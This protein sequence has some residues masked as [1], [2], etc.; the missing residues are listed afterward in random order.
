MQRSQW[1]HDIAMRRIGMRARLLPSALGS[2]QPVGC[3][4]LT[5]FLVNDTVAI[6][7]G[8]LG[9]YLT[10]AEQA[11]VRHVFISHSHLDHTGSL[12]MF[13]DNIYDRRGEPVTVHA[14]ADV[15]D[16]VQEHLLNE[17]MWVDYDRLAQ[18][19]PPFWNRAVLSPGHTVHLESLRITPVPVNHVVPTIG[20]IIEDEHSAIIITSDTGPTEEIWRRANALPNLRAVFLE[21]SFPNAF[22]QVA[23]S[24]KHLTPALFRQEVAK[25]A[26][27]TRVLAVHLKAQFVRQVTQELAAL[28]LANLE[29]AEAGRVYVF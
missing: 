17:A 11:R 12:P 22:A 5:T 23:E 27:P 2:S 24:A 4:Y 19:L 3:Q 21:A 18:K 20:F 1:G 13:I 7:A 28:G 26:R 29:I 25:L 10:P 9:F 8:S 16:Q 15:L 14:S 6:D